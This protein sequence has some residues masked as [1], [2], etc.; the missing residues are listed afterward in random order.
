VGIVGPSG[1]G[2]STLMALLLRTYDPTQGAVLVN[3]RDIRDWELRSLRLAFGLVPQEQ[4]LFTGTVRENIVY[5]RGPQSD[6]RIW[7]ALEEAEAAGFVRGLDKGLGSRLG[8]RGVSLSG[9]QKQRLAIARA[10][11]SSPQCLILDNCTSALD[12]ET[13]QRLQQTLR[14]ILSGR[15]AFI[16]S[17]RASSVMHCRDLW[18][19]DAGRLVEQGPP[20]HLMGSPGYF[21]FIQQAQAGLS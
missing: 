17:H 3:G 12:G 19:L 20:A 21:R 16:I 11:L 6:A 2:K 8:E 15:S 4:M 10:L 1:A 9:G 13:E 14:R 18:V 5:A 7:A